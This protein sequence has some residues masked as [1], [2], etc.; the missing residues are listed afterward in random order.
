MHLRPYQQESVNHA[1]QA[2][3]RGE[4]PVIKLPTGSGKSIVISELCRLVL[5][6]GGRVLIATHVAEL[7][8]QNAQEYQSLTGN[9]PGILCAGLERTD[10]GHDVLFASVQSLYGPA[11]RGEIAPFNLIIVDEC[12]LCADRDSDA[13]FYPT[14][15]SSFPDAHRVGLSATPFRMDGPVYGEGKYFTNLAYEADVLDLVHQGYLAPLVGVNASITLDTAKFKKVAGDYDQR[16]VEEQ[17]TD[18]WL[19]AVVENVKEL[20][21]ERKH[22]GVFCPT[23]ATAERASEIFTANGLTSSVV[24][25]DTEDRTGR[26]DA[27]KA[28]KFPVMCSVNVLSTGFNFR[29]LDCIVCLRPTTSLGLWQQVLGRGTRT[30]DGKKN[31]LVIDYSGNLAQHGG[32]CAGMEDCYQESKSGKV[33]KVPAKPKELPVKRSVKT[34]TELTDLD[35]M[36][37][38]PGGLEAE[39]LAMTYVVINSKTVEGKKLL[40]VVYECRLDEGVTISA[41]QFVCCEYEGYARQQAID[42]FARRGAIAPHTS[43]RAQTMCWGLP[44]PRSVTIKRKNKYVNVLKEHF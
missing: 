9:E 33:K 13:K 42:W 24:V 39:V 25:G 41:S 28:G 15:F 43:D 38:S 3:R 14:A 22:I 12:H 30:F 8:S 35:P 40:M 18:A 4:H 11:K 5:E 26:L 6:N 23:V 37:A 44:E 29:A 1:W 19:T 16:S 34:S 10:K 31:C 2:L 20:A 7:V 21:S 36:L 27:W 17:E 32:I